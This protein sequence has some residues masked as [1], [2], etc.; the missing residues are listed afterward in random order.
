LALRSQSFPR[1]GPSSSWGV[2]TCRESS[3]GESLPLHELFYALMF[4]PHNINWQ[5]IELASQLAERQIL[6]GREYGGSKRG[7]RPQVAGL[8]ERIDMLAERAEQR[9][10]LFPNTPVGHDGR[11]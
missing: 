4:A 10:S 6:R 11:A 7:D 5:R 1:S 8:A 9:L 3:R 2:T